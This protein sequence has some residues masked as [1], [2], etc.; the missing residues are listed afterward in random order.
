MSLSL[1]DVAKISKNTD[2]LLGTI[3]GIDIFT[4]AKLG[5]PYKLQL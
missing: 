1:I 3:N 5:S 4:V 2:G